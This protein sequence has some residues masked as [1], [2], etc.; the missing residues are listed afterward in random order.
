M[1]TGPGFEALRRGRVSQPGARYLV[2][3]T[4]AFRRS[5]ISSAPV[6][7]ALRQEIDALHSDHSWQLHGAVIM[8][9]HLHILVTLLERLTLGQAIGRLKAR[10]RAT[11]AAA[12]LTWQGNYFDHRLRPEDELELVL[13]YMFLNPHRAQLL[14]VTER[15]RWFWL[16]AAERTWFH[17]SPADELPAIVWLQ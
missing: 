11:L 7:A 16:G 15:Y 9:D 1:H 5:G 2:T 17:A 14:P 6:A 10:T 3:L 4:T 8:P 13:R 12:S